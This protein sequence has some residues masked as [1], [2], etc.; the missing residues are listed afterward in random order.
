ML[1]L[2]LL[3]AFNHHG[4]LAV[5]GDD[6]RRTG[7]GHLFRDLGCVALEVRNGSNVFAGLHDASE[8]MKT[9]FIPSFGLSQQMALYIVSDGHQRDMG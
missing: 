5:L 8:G 6:E 3:H 2:V 7:R 1:F 9:E 4:G